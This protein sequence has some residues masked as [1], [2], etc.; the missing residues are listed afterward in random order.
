MSGT[1][2]FPASV[3]ESLVSLLMSKRELAYLLVD[4]SQMLVRAGGNLEHFG[5]G[6]VE[7]GNLASRH[8]LFLEGLLPLHESP[9]LITSLEMPSARVADVHMYSDRDGVW[10]L[11]VDVTA[12]HNAARRVQQKAYDMTLLSEREARLIAQLET[13]NREL[14]KAHDELNESREA[15]LRTHRRLEQELQDAARYILSI[16]PQPIREPLIADWRYIPSTELGGDSFGYHW[17]DDRHFALY[18]LDVCGHGVGPALLSVVVAN[19]LR[20]GSL[21]DVDFRSPGKV[22]TALN[23]AYPMENHNDLYFTIWYGVYD[24]STRQLEYASAG[25]PPAILIA[26]E[27]RR[28]EKLK[29]RGSIV[30][31]NSYATYQSHVSIL[32]SPSRLF[33]FSDGTFEIRRPDGSMLDFDEFVAVLAQ[34][35]QEGQTELDRVLGFV[36][37]ARGQESFEDDFSIVKVEV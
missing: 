26:E 31:I 1:L 17:L 27:G 33:L 20:S 32:P 9:F 22:L 3:A 19:T 16:L 4:Q 28:I 10:V 36:R 25:H 11:L 24:N 5:L 8:L 2:D 18:L 21:P 13:A 34:P 14:K 15:L 23:Q 30:G 12:E 29:A 35:A 7:L 37:E 6:K